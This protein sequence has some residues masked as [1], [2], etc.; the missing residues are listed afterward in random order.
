MTPEEFISSLHSIFSPYTTIYAESSSHRP[1]HEFDVSIR[2][3]KEQR[4][5]KI[6][7]VELKCTSNDLFIAGQGSRD[8]TKIEAIAVQLKMLLA[9]KGTN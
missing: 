4:R 8:K 5:P 3:Y 1:G 9:M 6:Y 7:I 2:V